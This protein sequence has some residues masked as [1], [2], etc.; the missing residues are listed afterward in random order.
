[1]SKE[2]LEILAKRMQELEE[3]GLE[4]SDE[5]EK[6]SNDYHSVAIDLVFDELVPDL[7]L[8]D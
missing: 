6:L 8:P 1:M 7:I 4:D 2:I 5:Y 3:L